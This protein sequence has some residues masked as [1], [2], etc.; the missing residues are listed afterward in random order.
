MF[1]LGSIDKA[2]ELKTISVL[3]LLTE[4]NLFAFLSICDYP[5]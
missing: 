2:R 1:A 5:F 4:K 3:K